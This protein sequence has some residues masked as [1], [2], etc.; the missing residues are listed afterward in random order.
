M[1]IITDW[2]FGEGRDPNLRLSVFWDKDWGAIWWL[3]R[4]ED[5]PY[6]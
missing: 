2:Q 4:F 3:E 1:C 5:L 6:R